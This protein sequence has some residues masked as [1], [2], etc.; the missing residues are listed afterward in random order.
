[1]YK[2]LNPKYLYPSNSCYTFATLCYTFG[3]DVKSVAVESMDKEFN[4]SLSATLLISN[5]TPFPFNN[6]AL[7][8]NKGGLLSNNAPLLCK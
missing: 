8:G 2:S 7:L 6:P 1:M 3:F 4:I 5:D